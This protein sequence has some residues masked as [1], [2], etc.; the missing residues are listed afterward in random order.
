M[1]GLSSENKLFCRMI[2]SVQLQ[3]SYLL[4]GW[5]IFFSWNYDV[6]ETNGNIVKFDL[7][8]ILKEMYQAI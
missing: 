5:K 8:V 3:N 6:T 1:K 7:N 4:K 2:W